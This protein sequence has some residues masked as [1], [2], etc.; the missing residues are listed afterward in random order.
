MCKARKGCISTLLICSIYRVASCVSARTC[1]MLLLQSASFQNLSSPGRLKGLSTFAAAERLS[2]LWKM[3]ISFKIVNLK[4]DNLKN[5]EYLIA[6][7]P[8]VTKT[9]FLSQS[10]SLATTKL[11]IN[12]SVN[13][14]PIV[15][16]HIVDLLHKSLAE[17]KTFAFVSFDTDTMNASG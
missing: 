1:S 12:S 16:C 6:C 9:I 5:R 3:S 8:S 4:S 7:H 13:R 11:R 15:V 2:L 10:S 17:V 14:A